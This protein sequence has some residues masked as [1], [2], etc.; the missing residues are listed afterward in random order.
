MANS[1]GNARPFDACTAISHV[2][3]GILSQLGLWGWRFPGHSPSTRERLLGRIT[4]A[5]PTVGEFHHL[6]EGVV[7]IPPM[8]APAIVPAYLK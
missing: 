3:A 6:R 8:G 1:H 7:L 2:R 5:S 4:L